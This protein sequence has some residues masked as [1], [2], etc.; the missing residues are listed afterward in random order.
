MT[1]YYEDN[2]EEC[3]R[4]CRWEDYIK[5]DHNEIYVDLMNWMKSAYDGHYF[6]VLLNELVNTHISSELYFV[7]METIWKN[8]GGLVDGRTM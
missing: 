4:L 8:T 2:M 7:T 5:T 3:R 1:C 6:R